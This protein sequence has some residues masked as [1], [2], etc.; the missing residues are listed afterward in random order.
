MSRWE[1][2]TG[3]TSGQDYAA[4]FAALA[5][6]GKDMHGEARFCAALVPAGAR[7]LDAGCGTGRVMIRLAEQGY[8]CVGVDLDASMLAV[9]KEKA[10]GLPWFQVDLTR[11]DPALLGIT[12]DFD[13]VV[14]AGNVFPLLA[15]G[16]EATVVERLAAALRPGGLLVAGFGLDEA[17]LP[18]P[19]SITLP[20]YDDCCAAAGLTLVDRFAT[21]DADPYDDGGGYA[22]SV[23]RR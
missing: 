14:A 12:A 10:P 5:G 21:W 8:D 13:L 1:E 7:V 11:F 16:T 15:A 17:H 19:P 4:R 22:V 6:S 23:H 20:E 3:G 18:V 2:L 9:A